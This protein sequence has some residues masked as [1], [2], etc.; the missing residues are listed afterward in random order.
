[1]I[2]ALLIALMAASLAAMYLLLKSG[3]RAP[4]APPAPAPAKAYEPAAPGAPARHWSDEGRLQ[5]EVLA[6]SRFHAT[7]RELA[8]EH[9]DQGADTRLPAVL[10]VDAAN[11]YE[12]KPVAVFVAGRMVGYLGPRDAQYFREQQTRQEIAGQPV[13][14]DAAIRGGGLWNG[15]RLAYAVWLDIEPA[16]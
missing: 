5:T 2:D 14:C 1:M 12:D 3:F 8:G 13:S 9:G 7:V 10:A 11:P 6:E 4:A 15:K 16:R